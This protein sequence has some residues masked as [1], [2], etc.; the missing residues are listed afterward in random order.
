MNTETVVS[1]I[2]FYLSLVGLLASFVYI[3]LGTWYRDIATTE[4]EWEQF[5]DKQGV[6]DKW[7]EIYWALVKH[8]SPEPRNGFL[9]VTLFMVILGIFAL[10]MISIANIPDSTPLV[11]VVAPVLIFFVIYLFAAGS[12]VLKGYDTAKR[13][14]E[15]VTDKLE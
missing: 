5:K 11:F 6:R 8:K 7:I 4:Q 15:E 2:G 3:Q 12:Y 13:L 14:F 1:T 10:V 9:L